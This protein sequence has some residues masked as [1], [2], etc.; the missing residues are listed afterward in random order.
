VNSR[1]GL[2]QPYPFERLA[3]LLAAPA[4]TTADD[5]RNTRIAGRDCARRIDLSIGEPRHPAPSR[6]REAIV[7]SLDGLS[8][9]PATRGTPLLRE[10]IAAWI[11]RRYG[12][13]VDPMTELLPINGSRE[14]LFA[15]AQVVVDP[16]GGRLVVAPNP[17]YQI[18]EGAALLAGAAVHLV[19]QWPGRDFRCDWAAVPD[20]TWARTELLYVCSPGN[21]TGSVMPLEDWR[22]VFD[23]AERH[24]F[25][26][27]S[28]ECY[29]EIYLDEG[30]PPIGAL[31]AAALLGRGHE[32]LLVFSSLSKRSNLPGMRSGFVAGDPALI[33]RFLKYRTYHGSAMSPVW[34]AASIAAWTDEAH[35][36]D[37]RA[38][39]RA[40][41]A[42]V[43]P[44]LGAV[45]G[46][47][48]T[49]PAGF[50]VWLPVPDGDDEA[51]TRRLHDQYN[52]LVVPGSYLARVTDEGNP[53]RG[54]VRLALVDN[55]EACTEGAL[56][57]AEA[58]ARP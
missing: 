54:R 37:N 18:Y 47:G 38:L 57:I 55:L 31:Q 33:A 5:W 46:L 50:Y 13:R 9:Y 7:A 3:A 19:N 2:L 10:T 21:P 56:R 12:V 20:S 26:V 27:A 30:S 4:T 42:A 39:Y 45:D 51:F 34:Q 6:V 23:R 52:C 41:Y 48:P 44:L 40:K 53:G 58:L 25:V 32:R 29:S 49:P 1:L 16:N 11:E 22:V 17:F 43:M 28:D 36:R 15:I 8:S 35:V 24:G 14:A